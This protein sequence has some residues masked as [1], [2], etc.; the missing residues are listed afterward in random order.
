MSSPPIDDEQF[1]RRAALS[2]YGLYVVIVV[3]MLTIG[4]GLQSLHLQ[5]GLAASQLVVLLIPT[6]LYRSR[7]ELPWPSFRAGAG[8]AG[9]A[10]LAVA[11]TV[12]GFVANLLTGLVLVLIPSLSELAAQYEA[13]VEQLVR[14]DDPLLA[15]VGAVSICVIAPLC[16]EL[17]FRGTLLEAQ[18]H[19]GQTT[20]H[21]CVVNGVLFSFLH[22]NPFG[23][24]GLAVVGAFFAHLTLLTRSIWPAIFAH[25]VLNGVNGLLVPTALESVIA[26]ATDPTLTQVLVGLAVT[27]PILALLWRHLARRLGA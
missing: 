4:A 15:L 3:A 25:A 21:L 11:A 18:R 26:D 2:G 13:M 10:I 7:V 22:L 16:E 19:R 6:L 24:V 17:F 8:P 14:P 20:L 12:L 27:V 9:Y 23:F 5:Y 1:G